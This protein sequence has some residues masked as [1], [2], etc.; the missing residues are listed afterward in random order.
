METCLSFSSSSVVSCSCEVDQKIFL[1]FET[2]LAS[3]MKMRV[4][5]VDDVH[6]DNIN[7]DTRIDLITALAAL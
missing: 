4:V 6:F 2:V 1:C 5:K 3:F 7:Y